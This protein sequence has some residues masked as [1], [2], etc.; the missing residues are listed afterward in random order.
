MVEGHSTVSPN[1]PGQSLRKGVS[2]QELGEQL[3]FLRMMAEELDVKVCRE[4][5][6]QRLRVAC[7]T[8]ELPMLSFRMTRS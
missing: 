5:F 1:P 2:L 4:E 7:W 6:Q 3:S 8:A